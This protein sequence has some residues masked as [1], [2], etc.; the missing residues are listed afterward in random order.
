MLD[1]ELIYEK[2]IVPNVSS[3][4]INAIR[5]GIEDKEFVEKMLD[6]LSSYKFDVGSTDFHLFIFVG[7]KSNTFL[8]KLVDTKRKFRDNRGIELLM[9]CCD[10]YNE[11]GKK[12]VNCIA[13]TLEDDGT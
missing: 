10:R 11:L 13:I 12:I 6:I 3:H 8:F 5:K 2:E 7:F 9:D 4:V 1:S